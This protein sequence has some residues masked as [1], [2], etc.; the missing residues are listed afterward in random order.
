LGIGLVGCQNV[1]DEHYAEKETQLENTE[2]EVVSMK[3]ADFLQKEES[4]KNMVDLFNATG[5]T[6]EMV[7]KNQQLF[8]VLVAPNDVAKPTVI[9]QTYFAKSHVA[10]VA[11]SPSNLTN[12]QR[13]LMWNG[14]Y[15]EVAKMPLEDGTFSLLFGGNHVEKIIRAT[16]G[17]IYVLDNYISAPQSMYEIISN[18]GDDYSLFRDM[19]MSHNVKAFDRGASTPID[20]DNTGATVYDSVFTATNPYFAAAGLDIMSESISAT[21]LIPSNKVVQAAWDKAVSDLKVWGMTRVDSIYKNWV[22]QAAFFKQKYT[23]AD[24]E[25]NEDLESTFKKQWR[26]TVQKV[27]LNHPIEMS[28]GVAYYVDELKIPTNVLIYRIKDFFYPYESLSAEEKATLYKETDIYFNK[29]NT[30]VT[31]WSGW[32]GYF[33]NIINRVLMYEFTDQTD[34]AAKG[35]LEFTPYSYDSLSNPKRAVVYKIPAGEYT[36]SFG[37]KQKMNATVDVYFNQEFLRN[38]PYTT[39]TTY[40]YDRGAGGYPEGYDTSKATNSKKSNY[41]RDG[42]SAG[43]ITLEG[44]P[45]PINIRFEFTATAKGGDIVLHHWCLKPTKNCY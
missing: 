43:V 37:F 20:I 2:V 28:N 5:V 13:V 19:V 10:D 33:P 7:Q 27:D 36:L 23:K 30:D 34:A 4:L 40:H 17:Y 45:A 21:M 39:G 3:V 16:N 44:D 12:G 8:T 22:F 38:I 35:S 41:D 24:F 26:T 14:K 1:W 25:A 29:C 6:E 9:D 15:V 18:L 42:G 32:P 31:A 11:I